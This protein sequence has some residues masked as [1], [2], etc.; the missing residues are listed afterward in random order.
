MPWRTAI[1][2]SCL[3]RTRLSATFCVNPMELTQVVQLKGRLWDKRSL[4]MKAIELNPSYAFAYNNLAV[5][6]G[7]EDAHWSLNGP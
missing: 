1:W 7:P 6:L 3:G 5:L 2:A 4:Y